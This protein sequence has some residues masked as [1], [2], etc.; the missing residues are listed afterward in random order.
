MRALIA[1]M[2]GSLFGLCLW[3]SGMVETTRVLGWLD[4]FGAWD[5]TLAFVLGG[6]ILAMAMAMAWRIAERRPSPLSGG[7]FL[8][9]PGQKFIPDLVVGSLLFGA[10]W[11]WSVSRTLACVAD[12]RLIARSSLPGCHYHRNASSCPST[13][14]FNAN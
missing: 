4:I 14:P 11:G 1:T 12:F 6:A 3:V 9:R 10:G 13:P 5:P 7:S 8:G 2:G